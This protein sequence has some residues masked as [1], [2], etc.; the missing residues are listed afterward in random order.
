VSGLRQAALLARP[1]LRSASW[2][3]L[4]AG[5]ALALVLLAL[6]DRGVTQLRLA[7]IVL[8]VGAA[9]VLDDAAAATVASAPTPLLVRRAVRVALAVAPLGALWA[10]LS[11]IADGVASWAVSLEL[12]AMLALTLAAAALAARIRGDGRGGVAAGPSLLALLAAAYLLLPSRWG[13][14][15]G[16]PEDPLWTPAHRRWA[17]ILLAC[18][19]GGLWGSRDPGAASLGARL[20]RR[21]SGRP[22][23]PEARTS[24]RTQG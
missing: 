17:L 18:A 1:T 7:A 9:F 6:T 8:C 11:V 23:P 5:G 16:G 4:A 24:E 10:L 22:I 21:H 2:A 12:A 19:L 14:F 15:P 13:L 3:P 20:L